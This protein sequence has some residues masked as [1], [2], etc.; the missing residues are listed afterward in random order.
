[1]WKTNSNLRKKETV[2]VIGYFKKFSFVM[3][4]KKKQLYE[5]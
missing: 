1:M 5:D 3:E 2:S 4:K